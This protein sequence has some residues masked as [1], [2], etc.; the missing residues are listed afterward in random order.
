[1]ERPRLSVKDVRVYAAVR[2][3]ATDCPAARLG[4][5]G[6][7]WT[8]GIV[9]GPQSSYFVS[10]PKPRGAVVGVSFRPGAAEAI[11]G[12]PL[13]ELTDQHVAI[14]D[15]WGSRGRHLHEQLANVRTPQAAFA[16]LEATL[17]GRVRRP[18]LMHPAVAHALCESS[19]DPQTRVAHIQRQSGY[20][21]RHFTALFRASV[22]LTPKQYLRIGRFGRVLEAL[23]GSRPGTLAD[24][25][26]ANGYADQAH[27]SREFRD[28][29]GITPS[30]YQP[31]GSSSAHHHVA[32]AIVAERAR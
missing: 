25:A 6:N 12:L 30:A 20:S 28:L 8:R 24:L 31:P 14:D 15:L 4:A 1:V 29:A 18:L 32:G 23:A 27:L 17:G 21:A 10:G 26:A 16:L 3:R 2:A 22:G 7:A 13:T 5:E 19:R 9:H 11:L